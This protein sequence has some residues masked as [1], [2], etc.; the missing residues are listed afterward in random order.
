MS[1]DFRI[2]PLSEGL[3]LGSL[4]T[5]TGRPQRQELPTIEIQMMERAHQDVYR[6]HS[7]SASMRK[8][9]KARAG[10]M[11]ARAIAGWGLDAVMVCLTLIMCSVLGI[12]SWRFGS[13]ATASLDPLWS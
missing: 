3:G 5:P 1:R 13:G 7:V 8:A 4:R 10:R 6:K 12:M 2:K 9:P 11:F